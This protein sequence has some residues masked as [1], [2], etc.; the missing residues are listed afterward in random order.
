MMFRR[1]RFMSRQLPNSQIINNPIYHKPNFLII[2]VDQQR[3]PVVYENEE[4]KA[5]S[6][7]Y[8]KSQRILKSRGVEFKNHYAGSTACCPSRATLYTGQ[9]PSLHGVTQTDGA[10][11]GAY[12]PDM[13][14][15]GPNT[16]P[17]M[18]GYFETA[19]YQTY[20]Q[21]KWHVSASNILVPG[22]YNAFFSYDSE[23]GEPISDN[24]QLYINANVLGNFGFNGWIGPE[25]HGA[26]PRNS[27]A[28]AATGISGRDVVYS[29]NT[30]ELIA[31]LNKEYIASGESQG[32]P[33][34]I[35]CSFVNPHDIAI[36]GAITRV[37]PQYS[38]NV[39]PSVPYIP[40]APTATELLYTKPIAQFS[41]RNIYPYAL[42]PLLDTL[43][44]RQLYYSL[45]LEVDR[46]ICKVLDALMESSFYNNTIVVFTSDHGELL[47]AHGGLFQ[48]WYQAYEETIHVPLI[49]H[50]PIL[51]KKSESINILT[52][53]VDILPTV[54]GLAGLDVRKIQEIL[55]NNHTDV[56]HLVGRDLSSLLQGRNDFQDYDEP[57]YFMTDDNITK[58][59][60]QVSVTGIPYH[61]VIQPNSIETV[62]A[63]LPTGE[64]GK[65]QIWKYSR[66]FDN[67]QFWSIPGRMEQYAYKG[68]C[69]YCDTL[70]KAKPVPDQYEMYNITIDPLEVENLAYTD[71]ANKD[72]MQIRI[73]LDG[74]LL[75]QCRKKRL[76]PR[77][78]RLGTLL[79]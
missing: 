70:T 29:Q 24:E 55:G 36:F 60:N 49:I 17:T 77:N 65:N 35:M 72:I 20:W 51:F 74:L 40:P 25:P 3:Y 33:W 61:A 52:S 42:Q 45:Q 12:D 5:W 9:Y 26:N 69:Y 11:K 21:G 43:F 64:N 27:G 23:N 13:F 7:E 2:M 68:P 78:S 28:S 34:L 18:G 56:H 1:Q 16:V 50:N 4:L 8:L 53:H 46:Q 30:V 31:K 15:L 19:G 66:Y 48:R 32:K 71:Y 75:E 14:W 59:L 57:I 76:Y 58:G 38:F 44:Y 54:L 63:A 73:A 6:K 39:D 67:P 62:I 47:G 10:A 79:Y 37:L 41:Y 22:T